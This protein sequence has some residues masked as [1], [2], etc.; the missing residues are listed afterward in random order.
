MSK[1]MEEEADRS[2][3]EAPQAAALR[4]AA[5]WGRTDYGVSLLRFSLPE[6][7]AI[8]LGEGGHNDRGDHRG[9][10]ALGNY[11]GLQRAEQGEEAAVLRIGVEGDQANHEKWNDHDV[12]VEQHLHRPQCEPG[13]VVLAKAPAQVLI[14]ESVDNAPHNVRQQAGE[15]N[16]R[17]GDAGQYSDD[18]A[19]DGPGERSAGGG[20]DLTRIG[21][22]RGAGDGDGDAGQY[23]RQRR[24]AK[25]GCDADLA[26]G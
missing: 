12:V 5:A 4:A 10:D 18:D 22:H 26:C 13:D 21:D 6:R 15:W 7:P 23:D 14:D 20:E 9:Q 2:P 1:V 19:A 24:A 17:L 3:V 8:A 11:P 16:P 25:G